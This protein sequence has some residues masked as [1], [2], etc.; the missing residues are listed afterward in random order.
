L[1]RWPLYKPGG[2]ERERDGAV[3]VAVSVV[4]EA[5]HAWRRLAQTNVAKLVEQ[6]GIAW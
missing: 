4:V 2:S 3:V 5:E 1:R 6:I